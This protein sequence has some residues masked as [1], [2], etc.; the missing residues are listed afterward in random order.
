M[1]QRL[2]QFLLA[3][4]LLGATGGYAQPVE[5]TNRQSELESSGSSESQS[6]SGVESNTA[7]HA[8][9]RGNL[10]TVFEDTLLKQGESTD[11]VTTFFGDATVQG[12][13]YGNVIV[14]AGNL[15]LNSEVDGDV[16]VIGGSADFGNHAHAQH[17]VYILGGSFKKAEGAAILKNPVVVGGVGGSLVSSGLRWIKSGLV[18]GRPVVPSLGWV[19]G[20]I[21]GFFLLYCLVALLL[22]GALASGVETCETHPIGSLLTGLLFLMILTP[23]LAMLVVSGVGIV[24]LPLL[25][26]PLI[27]LAFVGKV[28]VYIS[29]GSMFSKS[30]RPPGPGM[31]VAL[32]IGMGICV[33][34]GM[35]PYIGFLVWGFIGVLGIGTLIL[36][37]FRYISRERALA[38]SATPSASPVAPAPAPEPQPLSSTPAPE[39]VPPMVPPTP[40]PAPV[41]PAMPKV[42][43]T[44][45]PP[46]IEASVPPVLASQT[47]RLAG[48]WLRTLSL[49][50]DLVLVSGCLS[51]AHR[52]LL[53]PF[54]LLLY[55]VSFLAARGATIGDMAVGIKCIRLTGEPLNWATSIARSLASLFSAFPLGLGFFWMAWDGRKQTWHDKIVG[56]IVVKTHRGF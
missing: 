56:T 15:S 47:H 49:L 50:I 46:K 19:W 7:P 14:V 53:F 54:G 38:K 26:C 34:L 1:R 37:C 21:L 4:L 12:R 33:V 11:D 9:I 3:F 41:A 25:A 55:Y 20:I 13:V 27:L 16:F 40:T 45:T 43:V 22:R 28:V 32:A 8:R 42:I 17:D 48:F 51:V 35:I 18:L 36:S 39:P 31:F 29:L 30:L 2:F 5:P 52:M 24:L 23:I 44:P 10:I 6:S